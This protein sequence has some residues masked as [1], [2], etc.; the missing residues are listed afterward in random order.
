VPFKGMQRLWSFLI[1]ETY[2]V[3][4]IW[5]YPYNYK[6]AQFVLYANEWGLN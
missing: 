1:I 5:N 6:A 4:I 2:F 3:T